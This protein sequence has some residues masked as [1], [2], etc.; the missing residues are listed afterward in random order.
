MQTLKLLTNE[1]V[2]KVIN[3]IDALSD[4]WEQRNSLLPFFTLGAA[5]YLDSSKVSNRRYYEKA[6]R[7]NPALMNQFGWL[8]DLVID[9]LQQATSKQCQMADGQALPGFHIFK[10]HQQFL[11]PV[12]SMHIDLQHKALQWQE[13]QQVDLETNTLSFTLALELPKSGAGLNTWPESHK[14]LMAMPFWSNLLG[15][16]EVQSKC[17]FIKYQAGQMVIHSGELLHQ[18]APLSEFN[19]EDRRITLQGH[20]VLSHGDTYLLYW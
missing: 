18:I 1:Q 12:A 8:Y 7:L 17:T 19:P 6:A 10:A 11:N 2:V 5:S 14:D 13:A 9:G 20:A 15:H 4:Q 16:T 3:Q